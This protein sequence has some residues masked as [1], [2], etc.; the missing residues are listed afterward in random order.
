MLFPGL[1]LLILIFLIPATTLRADVNFDDLV[2]STNGPQIVLDGNT[3][4]RGGTFIGAGDPPVEI[5]GNGAT[6]ILDDGSITIGGKEFRITDVTIGGNFGTKIIAGFPSNLTLENVTINGPSASNGILSDRSTLTLNNVIMRDGGLGMNINGGVLNINGPVLIENFDTGVLTGEGAVI[7]CNPANGLFEIRGAAN[8]GIL[9]TGVTLN[10]S[11]FLVSQCSISL[12][13]N[14]STFNALGEID[15]QGGLTGLLLTNGTIVNTDSN[16]DAFTLRNFS[17]N[18]ILIMNSTATLSSTLF[19]NNAGY[20]IS[21]EASTVVLNNGSIMRNNGLGL[22]ARNSQLT[23]DDSEFANNGEFDILATNNTNATIT[24]SNFTGSDNAIKGT[25]GANLHVTDCEIIDPIRYGINIFRESPEAEL[26]TATIRNNQIHISE[27]RGDTLWETGINLIDAINVLVEGNDLTRWRTAIQYNASS[28]D[29]IGN[30]AGLTRQPDSP[31]SRGQALAIINGSFVN[32]RDNHFFETEGDNIFIVNDAS[33]LIERNILERSFENA[34]LVEGLHGAAPSS[35]IIRYNDIRRPAV[36][37]AFS[38]LASGIV[39]GNTIYIPNESRPFFSVSRGIWLED[40]PTPSVI[41]QNLIITPPLSCIFISNTH[42]HIIRANVLTSSDRAGVVFLNSNGLQFLN[43]TVHGSFESGVEVRGGQSMFFFQNNF[44]DNF[45]RQLTDGNIGLF[46]HVAFFEGAGAELHQNNF[47]TNLPRKGGLENVGGAPIDARQNWWGS[48]SGPSFNIAQQT[49]PGLVVQGANINTS[50]HLSAPPT[51]ARVLRD[52]GLLAG[53]LIVREG[54]V[55]SEVRVSFT[56]NESVSDTAIAI[57]TW[58]EISL[59]GDPFVQNPSYFQIHVDHRVRDV[60]EQ[61]RLTFS[62]LTND[63]TTGIS[64]YDAVNQTWQ[65]LSDVS[66]DPDTGY[67]SITLDRGDL[68][69]TNYAVGHDP[70]FSYGVLPYLLGLS[71]NVPNDFN[72]D[73]IIDAADL[74]LQRGGN[75]LVLSV[76]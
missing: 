39:T 24:G 23:V 38:G 35:A 75:Q 11:S 16:G 58:P 2:R 26:P 69:N 10:M 36:G 76:K 19:E 1:A 48:A 61:G 15:L 65:K 13:L 47:E 9:G 3:V 5:I 33:A 30:R 57:A 43:N 64:R 68:P 53:Q 55:G 42:N 6:I 12:S 50:N 28:G 70:D 21:A 56:L 67:A 52:E 20:P 25:R 51:R 54:P 37:V 74:F 34:V 27:G 18:G 63:E 7:N 31:G 29:V 66:Y 59:G 4:Y 46:Y 49:G 45:Q 73:G 72:G 41:E 40:C 62:F 14:N 71:A 8:N 32:V 60:L 17:Q 22:F 44:V